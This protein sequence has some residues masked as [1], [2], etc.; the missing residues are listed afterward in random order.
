MEKRIIN[1]FTLLE[2]VLTLALLAIIFSIAIPNFSKYLIDYNISNQIDKLYSDINYIK[3]YSI[4]HHV[5]VNINISQ[6]QIKALTN[7]TNATL[8]LQ[9]NFGYPMSCSNGTNNIIL[10]SFGI[11]QGSTSCYVEQENNANP[12]CF[13]VQSSRIITGR[14]INGI[15]QK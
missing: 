4:S 1:A 7:E 2:V 3:F 5:P 8:I 13:A 10:N 15:C 12:N 9:D 6:S 14:W 11:A